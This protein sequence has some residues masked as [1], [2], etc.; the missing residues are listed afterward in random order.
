MES[1]YKKLGQLVSQVSKVN[2][3]LLITEIKGINIFK[4]FIPSVANT[5]GTDLSKYKVVDKNQFAYNPMHV[6]RDE[7]LPIALLVNQNPVIVS[8]AYIVFEIINEKEILPEYLMLWS[9]RKEF[10]RNA[11]YTT[12]SSVRGGLAWKEF[13][14]LR[15]YVPSIKKQK[16]LIRK[17]KIFTERIL[18][19]QKLIQKLDDTVKLLFKSWFIDFDPVKENSKESFK[20]SNANLNKIF[21]ISFKDSEMGMIPNGWEICSASDN[22]QVSIGRTPPREECWWFSKNKKDFPWVSIRDMSKYSIYAFETNEYLKK[23]AIEKFNIKL[24]P[25]DNIIVSFKLTLGRVA[26]TST[27]MLTNEAIAHFI[28]LNNKLPT[29]FSY[30]LFSTFN[31]KTLGSTSSIATAIN[32]KLLKEMKIIDPPID[33]KIKFH[34]TVNPIFERIRSTSIEQI[35]LEKMRSTILPKFLSEEMNINSCDN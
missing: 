19:N 12:D 11:W 22:Y 25:A 28:P 8:P 23:D 24:V 13:C 17:Y 31:Y 2:S 15:I 29:F 35:L 16:D 32:S 10:D 5:L 6:G 9:R 20:K 14:N 18:L 1:N 27:P 30:C 26:I 34:D 4:E 3:D 21:P 33:L 7:I